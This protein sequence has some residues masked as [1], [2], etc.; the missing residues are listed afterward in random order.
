MKIYLY[1]E[2][3]KIIQTSGIGRAM[4][5][6]MAALTSAGI[7]FS[8]EPCED[9]DILHINT[10]GPSSYGMI[11]KARK[12]GKKRHLSCAQYR[13]GFSQLIRAFQSDRTVVQK[14]SGVAL[15]QSGLYHYADSLF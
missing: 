15:Q 2:G 12:L 4:K 6:Q 14:A 5:H 7:D 10:V 1:F 13:R 11:K 8:I 9:Y 3:E